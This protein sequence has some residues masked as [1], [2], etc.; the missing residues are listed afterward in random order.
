MDPERLLRRLRGGS[1]ADVDFGDMQR[2]MEALGFGLRRVSGSHHIFT[3]PELVELV[4]LQEV[5]GQVKPYQ[6]RQ[7]LRLFER[8][9]LTLEA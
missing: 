6:V 1:V 9:D 7:C 3:H 8:Y 5:R 4:N 2:L